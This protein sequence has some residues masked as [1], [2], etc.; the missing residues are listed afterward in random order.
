MSSILQEADALING[1]R[2]QDYGHP[3]K[4]LGDIAALWSVYI[5]SKYGTD[6]HLDCEDVCQMMVLLKMARGFNGAKKRDSIVDQAAYAGLIG[7]IWYD[8]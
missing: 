1:D 2:E 3:K 5:S 6:T 8:E 7:R 4:N